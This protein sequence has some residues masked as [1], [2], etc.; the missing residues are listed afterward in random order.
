MI[1]DRQVS[2]TVCR[3]PATKNCQKILHS[4]FKKTG[5][6]CDMSDSTDSCA[7]DRR[8]FL[9]VAGS[10]GATVAL[11]GCAGSDTEQTGNNSSPGGSSTSSSSQS[12]KFP[13][14]I[15]QGNMPSTLD[16]HNHRAIP[17]DIVMLQAYEGLLRRTKNGKIE[18]SLATKWK[19]KEPGRVRFQIR[20]GPTFHKTG[21]DL[22]PADVAYSINRIVKKGVGFASPQASQLAGVTGAKV[23]DG[24]RAVDVMSEGLNPIVFAE[25]AIYCDIMEKQWVKKHK[26]SYIAKHM[27][28][29]GPF[30]LSN[31]QQNVRVVFDR[32][33]NYWKK[34]AAV[35]KL[36]FNSAKKS[37]V[38]VNKLIAGETD[39]I[40]NVP[41][42]AVGRIKQSGN[43]HIG[44]TGS[45]RI[46][47]NAMRSDVAPFSSTKFRQAMNYAIDLESIVKNVLQGFGKM[48]GQPT[49]KP[50]FGYADNISPYAFDK[51]KAERLVEESGHA[52][53]SI[54]L[55]TPNGRYLKDVQIAQAVANYIDK[56]SN[57]SCEIK[58][59]DFNTLASELTDGKIKTSPKF[60]LIGWG[61]ATFDASQTINPLLT[62]DGT[63][64]SYKNKKL[65]SLI[66]RASSTGNK[67]KRR[68]LL[69]QA[70]T[71]CHN[72]TPWIFLN[73][74]YGVYGIA[75]RIQW[76]P[77]VDERIDAYNITPSN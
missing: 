23:V 22:T 69:Q 45:T 49:L 61:N 19:R 40:V 21:N 2:E 8:S 50:F 72:Q 32:Y 64:T 37:G 43:A 5:L 35:S 34:P 1:I 42:K 25:F 24:Q 18:A 53:A 75:G 20:D 71:L 12:G 36:T 30:E 33:D 3:A 59:R 48:T 15:T 39:L 51:K 56:L 70:N 68:K 31:Y 16:P 17:T 10:A 66:K 58:Q 44:A 74:Q 63:L 67:K 28:G 4:I 46:L 27:N 47:Y 55:H 26:K 76:K 54:T 73:R 7:I 65:D 52:G 77:R 11:A 60:Y 6:V 57:V 62:S 9:K 41:P 14:T 29:T 38:R 13:V